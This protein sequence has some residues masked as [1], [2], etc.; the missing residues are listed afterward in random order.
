MSAKK[1]QCPF[2]ESIFA[3]TPEQLSARGGH[4]RCGK[5]FQVFKAD[6]HLVQPAPIGVSTPMHAPAAKPASAASSSAASADIFDLLDQPAAHDDESDT[7]AGQTALPPIDLRQSSPQHRQI[8]ATQS[9]DLG[10]LEQKNDLESDFDALFASLTPQSID[11][12]DSYAQ[13]AQSKLTGTQA[14]VAHPPHTAANTQRVTTPAPV[15][16]PILDAVPIDSSALHL[17]ALTTKDISQQSAAN[18]ADADA[19]QRA[20][21]FQDT[22]PPG[23]IPA[24]VLPSL[25]APVSTVNVST[26]NKKQQTSAK[27]SSL[28]L[29]LDDELSELFLGDSGNS[30][31]KD[32]LKH[33][34]TASV[35]KLSSTADESWADALLNEEENAKKAAAEQQ[36]A[37]LLGSKKPPSVLKPS[38]APVVAAPVPPTNRP[39]AHANQSTHR[40]MTIEEDD[41]LSYLSQVGAT[42][43]NT[44]ERAIAQ[45]IKRATQ[46]LP[47][48]A[49]HRVR[50]PVKPQQSAGHY[51]IWSV[52]CV[53][54]LLLLLAQVAYFN[55]SNMATDPRYNSKLTAVCAMVGCQVPSMDLTQ[56]S[57]SRIKLQRNPADR[58]TTRVS[59]TLTNQANNS[60]LMPD[61]KFLQLDN[62][63]TV[64]YRVV[65]P[66][67]TCK[68]MTGS[69]SNCCRANP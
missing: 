13:S 10:K 27:L 44:E 25:G 55:F 5:C 37:D 1:T 47:P 68:T 31:K 4:V 52:L 8:D 2:C 18:H 17:P 32:L 53:L 43:Q 69:S 66:T 40:G 34:D 20:A 62:R 42:S 64:A 15:A 30:S 60:Q 63:E 19:L 14:V 24:V 3:V 29:K 59:L 56:I 23:S 46:A 36:A 28:K 38:A 12:N 22:P 48:P 21:Q 6:E 26:F 35:D 51:V 9:S 58:N 41:L 50:T 45:D 7:L 67:N 16:Q 54:M 33:H 39:L 65:E 49:S 57:T 61:L 11:L